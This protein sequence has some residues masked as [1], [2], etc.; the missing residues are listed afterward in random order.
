VNGTSI[1]QT[2]IWTANFHRLAIIFPAC[3]VRNFI[4][5]FTCL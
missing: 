4:D 2:F 5:H 1:D 3:R